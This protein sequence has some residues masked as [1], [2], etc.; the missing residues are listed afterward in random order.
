MLFWIENNCSP[1]LPLTFP[2]TRP[3]RSLL[4]L[5]CL[6]S[7]PSGQSC[8]RWYDLGTMIY[9]LSWQ[10]SFVFEQNAATKTSETSNICCFVCYFS[11][12]PW[13]SPLSQALMGLSYLLSLFRNWSA[14]ASVSNLWSFP[15]A[16]HPSTPSASL[17]EKKQQTVRVKMSLSSNKSIGKSNNHVDN[18]VDNMLFSDA[19]PNPSLQAL[20]TSKESLTSADSELIVQGLC[21]SMLHSKRCVTVCHVNVVTIIWWKYQ[22][23]QK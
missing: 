10:V 19:E 2:Q 1:C 23:H 4:D 6:V 5:R 14:T 20:N 15:S 18:N 17:H 13:Y 16:C 7:P 3:C 8:H 9:R 12:I 22:N 21:S 11:E